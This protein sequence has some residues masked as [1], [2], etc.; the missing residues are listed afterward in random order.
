MSSSIKKNISIRRNN[1]SLNN[2]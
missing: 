1:D 2:R